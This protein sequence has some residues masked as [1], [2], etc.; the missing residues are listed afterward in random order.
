MDPTPQ[1]HVL[2]IAVQQSGTTWLRS[3]CVSDVPKREDVAFY[4]Q[5]LCGFR[6]AAVSVAV[7]AVPVEFQDSLLAA[8]SATFPK[9]HVAATSE[10]KIAEYRDYVYQVCEAE[11]FRSRMAM[12]LAATSA[13]EASVVDTG[14]KRK[15]WAGELLSQLNAVESTSSTADH[16]A[17]MITSEA[18]KE[19]RFIVDKEV[20]ATWESR[21]GTALYPDFVVARCFNTA[22][23]AFQH[24]SSASLFSATLAWYLAVRGV[25]VAD[26]VS[27][28]IQGA[29]SDLLALTGPFAATAT[30]TATAEAKAPEPAT[31]AEPAK[32]D[33]GKPL[34]TM[35]HDDRPS[36]SRFSKIK[37]TPPK[38][39]VVLLQKIEQSM[40]FSKMEKS[41]VEPLSESTFHRFLSY[42]ARGHG[43]HDAMEDE[44]VETTVRR[45][46]TAQM[47]FSA[48]TKPILDSWTALWDILMSVEGKKRNAVTVARVDLLLRTLDAWDA[49]ES[50]VM[51][52][53]QRSTLLEDWMA[54]YRDRELVA[55]R[56]SKTSFEVVES[57]LS[58][59]LD[60]FLPRSLVASLQKRFRD[61]AA[62]VFGKRGY[63]AAVL[64]GTLCLVGARLL[65]TRLP[66]AGKSAKA[67]KAT[68][69]ANPAV[70]TLT[71]SSSKITVVS[72]QVVDLGS[73]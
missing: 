34:N 54:V 48:K 69:N 41:D 14:K 71:V 49:C 8:E 56:G 32:V 61:L 5:R 13:A 25:A 64:S 60:K 66:V 43:I 68:Y 2:L 16:L 33:V 44:L 30:A 10:E 7:H 1:K 22:S 65:G 62:S 72:D 40:L 46:V 50:A 52:D 57:D 67:T 18:T 35:L 3:L 24:P 29:E 21:L 59:Y 36:L 45:W 26:G 38:P 53:E 37:A 27:G 70:N 58:A 55:E 28:W 6:D 20:G 23:W 42:M 15:T 4:Y 47:G 19:S 9:H 17:W 39:I 51:T 73:F 12:G 11:R 31:A 63:S